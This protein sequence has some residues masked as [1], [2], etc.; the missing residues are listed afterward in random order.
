MKILTDLHCHTLA[1]AHAYSTIKE[2]I[3]MAKNR[4]LEAVAVTDHGPEQEDAPPLVHF[5][6]LRAIPKV[7]DGVRVFSGCEANILDKT[8]R[9]DIPE[10]IL[11]KLDIVIASIHSYYYYEEKGGDH[12]AAYMGALQNRYVDILGHSGYPHYAYDID[13]V[14]KKAKELGKLIEINNATYAVRASSA[15]RCAEIAKACKK[16]G[17]HIAVN[18]DSHFCTAVGDFTDAVAMLRD[19]DFPEELIA[20]RNLESLKSFFGNRKK[21]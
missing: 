18:S 5:A 13:M 2:N 16:Y 10:K 8:G 1:S 9:I 15:E 6:N 3:D 12:T 11:E 4:G 7:V 20:N 14:V 21:I 19:I 17:T